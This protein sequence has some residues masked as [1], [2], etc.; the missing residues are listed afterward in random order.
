ME[1]IFEGLSRAV[2]MLFPPQRE[3]VEIALLSVVVSASA[4]AIAAIAAIPAG[5]AVA[6]R[7][8]RGRR[9]L[10]GALNAWLAVPAVAV[11]LFVYGLISRRGPMGFLGMLYT[12]YAMAA[13]QAVLAFPII[14]TLTVSALKNIA[15][16]TSELARA[17]G[18]DRLQTALAVVKEGRFAFASAVIMGFARV[19][20]ETGMTM[21]LGGNI[22]GETRVL[23]TAIALETMKGNF[24]TGLAL[25]FIL[26]LVAMSANALLQLAQGK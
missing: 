15:R 14:L 17:M 11:G 3:I 22:R 18:A 24:E 5:V 23:T 19:I 2:S 1:Y 20:G 13:A 4:T 12:P 21:M 10:V 9:F 7:D 26:I 8:F 6:L 25:G 16:E